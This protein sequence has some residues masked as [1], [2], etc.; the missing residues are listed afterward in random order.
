MKLLLLIC[1]NKSFPFLCPYTHAPCYNST[2][3]AIFNIDGVSDPAALSMAQT[4]SWHLLKS[5]E[6]AEFP[7]QLFWTQQAESKFTYLCFEE[8]LMNW[9]GAD[10]N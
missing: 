9:H 1:C 3:Q 10:V 8:M 6:C 4:E 2:P 7:S 5:L